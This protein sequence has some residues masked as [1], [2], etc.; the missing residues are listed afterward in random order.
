MYNSID[1][2]NIS[3]NK[4]NNIRYQFIQEWRMEENFDYVV[5]HPDYINSMLVKSPFKDKNVIVL[6]PKSFISPNRQIKRKDTMYIPF[7]Y[8]KVPIIIW[9]Q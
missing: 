5:C 3:I 1:F 8:K 9:Q 2:P 7:I 6:S 4:L